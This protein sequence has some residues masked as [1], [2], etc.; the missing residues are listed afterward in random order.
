[1]FMMPLVG[2]TRKRIFNADFLQKVVEIHKE[3]MGFAKKDT[4][5]GINEPILNMRG[6]YPDCGSGRFSAE[7]SYKDWYE[8][9]NAQRVHLNYVEQLPLIIVLLL[10]VSF[11]T[12]LASLILSIAYFVARLAYAVGYIIGGPNWRAIGALT[13]TAIKLISFGFSFYTCA[14]YM[15]FYNQTA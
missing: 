14:E 8:F 13:I 12:P 10:L 9:N 7:M 2:K 3:G 5:E 1:M 11:K 15:K 4:E 6:G